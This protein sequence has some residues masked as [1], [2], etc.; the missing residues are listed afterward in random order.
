MFYSQITVF[1]V[2]SQKYTQT[3]SLSDKLSNSFYVFQ[4]TMTLISFWTYWGLRMLRKSSSRLLTWATPAGWWV[5]YSTNTL[6]G[7]L[8][9]HYCEFLIILELKHPAVIFFLNKHRIILLRITQLLF[10]SS[11]TSLCGWFEMELG[12]ILQLC[13]V[14][15]TFTQLWLLCFWFHLAGTSYLSSHNFTDSCWLWLSFEYSSR[16]TLRSTCDVFH[17]SSTLLYSQI[18]MRFPAVIW[19]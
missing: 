2:I 14:Y 1:T 18:A 16:S 15:F 11:E 5:I 3:L 6:S 13:L 17:W 7:G 8:L 4:V 19:W 9:K 10:V 12:S